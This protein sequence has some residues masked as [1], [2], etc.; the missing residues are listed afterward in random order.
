MNYDDNIILPFTEKELRQ[1]KKQ[2]KQFEVYKKEI[3]LANIKWNNQID[4]ID[5]IINKKKSK[6]KV[7]W[8]AYVNVIQLSD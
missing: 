8:N 6:K 1:I 3:E 2:K 7:T 5:K 4:S